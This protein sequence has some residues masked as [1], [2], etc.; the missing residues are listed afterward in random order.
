MLE[1]LGLTPYG[2]EGILRLAVSALLGAIMGLE[3]T[4]KR[5]G[6]GMRTYMLVALGSAM[7]VLVGEIMHEN[8]ANA[9]TTR[10]AASAVSGIGFI[11]AGSIILSRSNRV[12]GLT[13]AAGVW[14]SVS[15]GLAVGCGYYVGGVALVIISIAA[16]MVGEKIQTRFLR[17]SSIIRLSIFFHGEANVLP[18][19]NE[20]QAL[21]CRIEGLDMA[22]PISD[23]VS[24]NMLLHVPHHTNH[25]EVIEK[26]RCLPGVVFAEDI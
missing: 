11:G 26:L 5:R 7:T 22:M 9:D 19:V 23:C 21:G 12:V 13:T 6:A 25:R 10:I 4:R 18:F 15:V 2:I 8:A 16:T 20:V 3:R 17:H 24:A 14:V 1:T